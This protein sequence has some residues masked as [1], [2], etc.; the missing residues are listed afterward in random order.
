MGRLFCEQTQGGSEYIVWTQDSGHLLGYATG[1]ASHEQ[2]WNWF[3]VIHHNIN[4]PGQSGIHLRP[5]PPT[6]AFSSHLTATDCH[7]ELRSGVLASGRGYCTGHHLDPRPDGQRLRMGEK[8]MPDMP[9]VGEEFA[10]YRL[11]SKLGWGGMSVVFQ[12]E[13]WRLGN[14]V[15]LKILA[16]D[17]AN[18][19]TFRTRF[20]QESRIAASLNH[21]NVVPISDYGASDGLLYIAMRYVAGTDLRQMIADQGALAPDTATYLLSQAALALDAAHRRGLVHRD[22]KPANLLIERTSDDADP[23]HLYLTDFGISKDVAGLTRLTSA[24]RVVGTPHYLSPEQAQELAVHGAAD[25]YALGCVLY[26]SL[27]GRVLFEKDSGT[28][29]ARAHVEEVALPATLLRPDLPPAVNEVFARVLAKRPAERYATCREFMAAA[30]EALLRT[31]HAHPPGGGA[32]HEFRPAP[33]PPGGLPEVAHDTASKPYDVTR[34]IPL[35]VMEPPQN[36]AQ[37][38]GPAG[39]TPGAAQWPF[40][41]ADGG[42]G[43][44]GSGKPVRRRRAR[45]HR[46]RR[47]LWSLIVIA[48]LVAGAAVGGLLA[49]QAG[50]A[51][52]PTKLQPAAQSS[53]PPSELFSVIQKTAKSN[54][55]DLRMS[56]CVQQ[57]PTRLQCT[58]PSPAIVSVTFATYASLAALYSDYTEIVH[59]LTGKKPFAAVENMHICG[60]TAPASTAES[61]WNN[62]NQYYTTYSAGQLASGKIP[63]DIAMGR[64]FCTQNANGSAVILWTQDS[65]KLLGYATGGDVSHQQVWAWFDAVHDNISFPVQPGTTGGSISPSGTTPGVSA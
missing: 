65:G 55:G 57:T 31:S 40:Y 25:Q 34:S 46:D 64:V 42:D 33:L 19:D 37:Y 27:T 9:R 38:P 49:S 35:P 22:V 45:R 30:R 4:F 52:V 47:T 16:P 59:N 63:T 28:A 39:E 41:P 7:D 17:L 53:P 32:S 56:A 36:E 43:R 15:A 10:G 62:S 44:G 58:N 8:T 24:G 2:V 29:I 6:F 21:P 48:I 13:N 50:K 1:A 23:D 20:L 5:A 12:A 14:V 11:R 51:K 61:T 3:S 26:E 18:D 60:A 54:P